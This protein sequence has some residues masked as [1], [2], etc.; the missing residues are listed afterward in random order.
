MYTKCDFYNFFIY[1]MYTEC[2]FYSFLFIACTQNVTFIVFFIYWM[3]TKCDFYSFF[4]Y[5]MNTK[6]DYSPVMENDFFSVLL[7]LFL[8]EFTKT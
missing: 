7:I 1:R 5:C 6:C 4:I 3:Y 8:Q 2:D